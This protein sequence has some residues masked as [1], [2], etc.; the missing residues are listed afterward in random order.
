[1][2]VN[3]YLYICGMEKPIKVELI[4]FSKPESLT[5]EEIK[6]LMQL[7]DDDLFRDKDEN[8]KHRNRR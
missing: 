5:K 2:Y 7:L 4:T 3:N 1:M 8:S 6:K